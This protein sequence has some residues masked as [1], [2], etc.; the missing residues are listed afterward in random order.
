MLLRMVFP[1][2]PMLFIEPSSLT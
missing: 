2:L 1:V